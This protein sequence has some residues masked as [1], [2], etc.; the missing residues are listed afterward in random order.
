MKVDQ[1]STSEELLLLPSHPP[2]CRHTTERR[3][4][5]FADSLRNA[6][7][8]RAPCEASMHY[9]WLWAVLSPAGGAKCSHRER[10]LP[11]TLTSA[12]LARQDT[13]A[14]LSAKL[15]SLVCPGEHSQRV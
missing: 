2:H 6:R 14:E 12:E 15:S 4:T 8:E 11:G 3:K 10:L 9:L 5:I 13:E 7:L 1:H